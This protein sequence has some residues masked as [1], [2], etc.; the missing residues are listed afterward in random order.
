M[1]KRPRPHHGRTTVWERHLCQL[2]RAYARP[3]HRH[4]PREGSHTSE[5]TQT[6]ARLFH[7]LALRLLPCD[8]R[9]CAGLRGL[10]ELTT[11]HLDFC[12]HVTDV[13]LQRLTVGLLTA[14]GWAACCMTRWHTRCSATTIP[15]R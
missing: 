5:Q 9:G 6:S 8:G 1:P 11:L 7:A 15:M 10:T 13:G 14:A 12:S 4:Q 2:I 3:K